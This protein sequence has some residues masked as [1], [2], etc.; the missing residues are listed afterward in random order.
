MD[1][2]LVAYD[3]SGSTE[4]C[5]YYHDTVQKILSQFESYSVV[6]WD[7]NLRESSKE[8]LARINEY[9][10]GNGGTQPINIAKY[11]VQKEFDG[12]F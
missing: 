11:C 7:T 2:I 9:R 1:K 12:K 5:A 3:Y 4:E 8:E 10:D 6:L